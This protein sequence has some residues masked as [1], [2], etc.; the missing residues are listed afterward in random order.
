MR[1]TPTVGPGIG[2]RQ[3]IRRALAS[4]GVGPYGNCLPVSALPPQGRIEGELMESGN[5]AYAEYRS[6]KGER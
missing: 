1:V 3:M 2:R 4:E 6:R 5:I